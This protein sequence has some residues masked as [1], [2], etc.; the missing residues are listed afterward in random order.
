MSQHQVFSYWF[1]CLPAHPLLFLKAEHQSSFL[2]RKES[3]PKGSCLL[4]RGPLLCKMPQGRTE[5]SAWQAGPL[6]ALFGQQRLAG[7]VQGDLVAMNLLMDTY[8]QRHTADMC[9]LSCTHTSA[10]MYI[11]SQYYI[12]GEYFLQDSL[13]SGIT[14]MV[15]VSSHT[16]P[17]LR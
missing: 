13:L 9:A 7:K 10:F 5:V 12:Y 3:Q 2:S 11:N 1:I 16:C 4:P 8:T 6:P 14:L 17:C 15:T